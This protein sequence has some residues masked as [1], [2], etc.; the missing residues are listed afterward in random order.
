MW[1]ANQIIRSILKE[2]R[3]EATESL[4]FDGDERAGSVVRFMDSLMDG[5]GIVLDETFV[6]AS[7]VIDEC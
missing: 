3:A 2:L 6:I 1:T 4:Y 7:E 5:H